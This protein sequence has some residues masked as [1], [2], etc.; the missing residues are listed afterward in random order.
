MFSIQREKGETM[1]EV[2]KRYFHPVEENLLEGYVFIVLKAGV[3]LT[4]VSV[5]F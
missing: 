3:P 4:I 5:T 1:A 2:L